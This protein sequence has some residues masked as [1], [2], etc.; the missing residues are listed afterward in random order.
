MDNIQQ[1]TPEWLQ[2]RLGKI[3][4]SRI[5]DV[6]AQG[7]T[8]ESLTRKKYKNNLV[9][10]RMT[11]LFTESYTN[12]AMQRGIELEPLARASYEIKHNLI[13]D[14]ISFVNHPTIKMAGASPDGL[15]NEDG[16]IEIKCPS[17]DNHIDNLINDEAPKKYFPQ[18][19]WQ[20]ACTGR[21]WCDFIS[22][23][24]DTNEHLRMLVKRVNRDDEWIKN[25]EQEVI[26][27]NQEIEDAITR[28]NNIKFE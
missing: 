12:P 5:I 15:V 2:L 7:K 25:T 24:P 18:M 27:F 21:K 14:Q 11:G 16:L 1:G 28:L 13:V 23:D 19:Q 26:K 22:F 10:Q 8:G 6:L 3:T 9:R 4:A 20:M 17:P